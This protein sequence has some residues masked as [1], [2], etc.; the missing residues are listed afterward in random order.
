MAGAWELMGGKMRPNASQKQPAHD[1][2]AEM[3]DADMSVQGFHIENLDD[4]ERYE[5]WSQKLRGDVRPAGESKTDRQAARQWGLSVPGAGRSRD[6]V[7]AG[8]CIR[9]RRVS[10]MDGSLSRL[11]G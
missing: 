4:A 6:H 11:W 5:I 1:R 9:R 2:I 7:K 3:V 8:R 10:Q